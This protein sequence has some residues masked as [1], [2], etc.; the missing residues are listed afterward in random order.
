MNNKCIW[1]YGW[2]RR[3]TGTEYITTLT[4]DIIGNENDEKVYT[5]EFKG[6]DAIEADYGKVVFGPHQGCKVCIGEYLDNPR[7]YDDVLL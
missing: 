2:C 1:K 5:V 6:E 4:L 7:R 3:F